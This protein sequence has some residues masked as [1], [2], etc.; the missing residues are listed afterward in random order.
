MYY[1]FAANPIDREGLFN[2]NS[3]SVAILHHYAS[4]VPSDISLDISVRYFVLLDRFYYIYLIPYLPI[5]Y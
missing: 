1:I 3:R 4:R 2:F 5:S